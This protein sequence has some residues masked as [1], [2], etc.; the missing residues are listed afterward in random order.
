MLRR[1]SDWNHGGTA[2]LIARQL[3]T[4]VADF[5]SPK[6]ISKLRGCQMAL[7]NERPNQIERES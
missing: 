4:I 2:A 5:R 7:N 3:Q 6:K 1:M